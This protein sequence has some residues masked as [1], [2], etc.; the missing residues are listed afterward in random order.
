M[1]SP[2]RKHPLGRRGDT[3]ATKRDNGQEL[4]RINSSIQ[5]RE[6]ISTNLTRSMGI[7]GEGN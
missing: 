6:N 2:E 7:G 4:E 5:N 3:Y 1:P